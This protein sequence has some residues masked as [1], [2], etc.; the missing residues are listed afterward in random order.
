MLRAQFAPGPSPAHVSRG[1]PDDRCRRLD[2]RALQSFGG[3]PCECCSAVEAV[4][5]ST[6]ERGCDRCDGDCGQLMRGSI[7]QNI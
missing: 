1:L 6:D 7:K 3:D 4:A 2:V 5:D